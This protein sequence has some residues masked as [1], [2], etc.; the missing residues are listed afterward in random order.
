M[1]NR[2]SSGQTPVRTARQYGRA[3]LLFL[4]KCLLACFWE[5][6][7]EIGTYPLKQA[8]KMAMIGKSG[9]PDA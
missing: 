9:I 5:I 7:N 4:C 1:L 3:R 2:R 6:I 8:M